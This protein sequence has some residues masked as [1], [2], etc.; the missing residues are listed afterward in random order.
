[1]Q[2]AADFFSCIKLPADYVTLTSSNS[3]TVDLPFEKLETGHV[4][5]IDEVPFSLDY[6]DFSNVLMSH[7]GQMGADNAVQANKTM[8]KDDAGPLSENGHDCHTHGV[9]KDSSVPNLRHTDRGMSFNLDLSLG[10]P[11]SS[12]NTLSY[13]IIFD[14][15]NKLAYKSGKTPVWCLGDDMQPYVQ[16]LAVDNGIC[17]RH[18]SNLLEW[19]IE[20]EENKICETQNCSE[21]ARTTEN[22]LIH[23]EGHALTSAERNFLDSRNPVTLSNMDGDDISRKDETQIP[24]SLP[25]QS[26]NQEPPVKTFGKL[27]GSQ[28]C[29]LSPEEFLMKSAGNKEVSHPLEQQNQYNTVH[30]L[31]SK[32]Q[33]FKKNSDENVHIKENP[34]DST[35]PSLKVCFSNTRYVQPLKLSTFI[36]EALE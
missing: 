15:N 16:P 12:A 1:M 6:A 11:C 31:M 20:D 4:D 26:F 9:Q 7:A 23:L 24:C 17:T 2:N 5:K 33:K 32:V 34:L 13:E 25:D 28:K 35:A 27:D 3:L 14:K 29:T 18:L 21:Y 22:H 10:P 8:I 19:R 36:L 30:K